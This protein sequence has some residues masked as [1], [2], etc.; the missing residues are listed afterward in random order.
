MCILQKNSNYKNNYLVKCN[1][2]AN[3]CLH[4]PDD[5]ALHEQTQ[6]IFLLSKSLKSKLKL[7][8]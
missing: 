8:S 2:N 3:E 6:L 4:K 7:I 1:N 5:P